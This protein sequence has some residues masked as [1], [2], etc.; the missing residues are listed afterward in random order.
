VIPTVVNSKTHQ[1]TVSHPSSITIPSHREGEHIADSVKLAWISSKFPIWFQKFVGLVLRSKI[2][3]FFGST[4]SGAMV[5]AGAVSSQ[6]LWD[7][8]GVQKD[9]TNQLI[10]DWQRLELDALLCPTMPFPAPPVNAPAILPCTYIR[11]LRYSV[12]SFIIRNV[13]LYFYI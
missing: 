7:A 13:K 3:P 9:I 11:F 10:Q 6:E 4:R 2:I 12:Y 5:G 1:F 8:A